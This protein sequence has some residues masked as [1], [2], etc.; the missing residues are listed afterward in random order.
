LYVESSFTPKISY[1]TVPSFDLVEFKC[2]Y[3]GGWVNDG[4]YLTD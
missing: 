4:Q 2:T 1:W 3:R